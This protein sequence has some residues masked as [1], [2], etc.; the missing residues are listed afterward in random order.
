MTTPSIS[1]F[2]NASGSVYGRGNA[3]EGFTPLI[4]PIT[5]QPVVLAN[6]NGV[7]GAAFVNTANEVIIA[8]EGTVS[9]NPG[10]ISADVALVLQVTPHALNDAARRPQSC[11]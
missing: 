4:N 5:G 9:N 3:P 6:D 10:S 2:L 8:F 7:Y 11:R 1:D